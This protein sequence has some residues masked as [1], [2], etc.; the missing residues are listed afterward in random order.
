MDFKWMDDR[1]MNQA[2][3]KKLDLVKSEPI[4]VFRGATP[5]YADA[6]A[7]NKLS[8]EAESCGVRQHSQ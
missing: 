4:R 8:T 1:S 2:R 7:P 5:R 3:P 6:V